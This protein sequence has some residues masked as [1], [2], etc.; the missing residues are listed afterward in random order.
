MPPLLLRLSERPLNEELHWIGVS[1]GITPQLHKFWKKSG[2]VPVYL[3]QTTNEITGEHTCIMIKQVQRKTAQVK[4]VEEQWLQLFSS[5]FRK[6]FLELLSF[7]FRAF[8]PSLVL[9]ILDAAKSHENADQGEIISTLTKVH[10]HF[11][12]FDLKRL[13]SY[14]QNMLDYHVIIDLVYPLSRLYFLGLFQSPGED[15]LKLSAVQSAILIGMGLQKKT[16]E[17]IEQDLSISVSQ[18]LALFAKSIR[19]F[20]I[21][22]NKIVE[23]GVTE[24]VEQVL[25][26]SKQKN[27]DLID[28]VEGAKNLDDSSQWEA[29][30]NTLADD[31][32]EGGKEAMKALK[33]KQKELID[34]LDLTA[35]G[36]T[37]FI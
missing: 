25:K 14:S 19:K 6:R 13:E 29:A 11:S 10:R 21:Y 32:D 27:K 36:F 9:S 4:V 3:R 12:A 30:E 5:D 8:S 23:Q 33:E 17:Q 26:E 16:V 37:I 31:L 1:Y 2:Y 7:Q 22:L 24:Q 34:S 28:R 35:Y 20:S 18:I 15:A